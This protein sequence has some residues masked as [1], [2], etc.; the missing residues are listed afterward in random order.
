MANLTGQFSVTI[1]PLPREEQLILLRDVWAGLIP[2]LRVATAPF[3]FKSPHWTF[4]ARTLIP[5][6]VSSPC[7][8]TG[9]SLPGPISGHAAF[10]CRPSS[11]TATKLTQARPASLLSQAPLHRLSSPQVVPGR[12]L[13]YTDPRAA[14]FRAS[15][16][17]KTLDVQPR[18]S[19]ALNDL[20]PHGLGAHVSEGP[21]PQG[22]PCVPVPSPRGRSPLCAGALP[23]CPSPRR[24]GRRAAGS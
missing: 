7:G 23:S 21:S 8:D 14:C 3:S 2:S 20:C 11:S 16:L 13:S 5:P 18:V 12:L 10:P 4:P 19:P 9:L 17:K 15:F 1:F 24:E 6:H 22:S